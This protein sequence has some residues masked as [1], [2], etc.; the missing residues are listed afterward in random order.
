MIFAFPVG[1]VLFLAAAG[2]AGLWLWRTKATADQKYREAQDMAQQ[3]LQVSVDAYRAA[4][5]EFV[6]AKLAYGLA[7]DKE[8]ALLALVDTWPKHTTPQEQAS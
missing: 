6:D 7:D 3:A 8:P 1:I 2:G 5:A 4:V